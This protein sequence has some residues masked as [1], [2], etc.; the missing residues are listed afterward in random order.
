MPD[1]E[2]TNRQIRKRVLVDE[3]I[4]II[5]KKFG[6][7]KSIVVGRLCLNSGLKDVWKRFNNYRPIIKEKVSFT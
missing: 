1:F 4:D 5:S 3:R 7:S 6:V 2:K